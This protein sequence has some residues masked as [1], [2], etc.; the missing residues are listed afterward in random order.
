MRTDHSNYYPLI[1]N[2]RTHTAK[3]IPRRVLEPL[4]KNL[5]LENFGERIEGK[6]IL[7][8]VRVKRELQERICKECGKPL[9]YKVEQWIHPEYSD[10]FQYLPERVVFWAKIHCESCNNRGRVWDVLVRGL[11]EPPTPVLIERIGKNEISETWKVVYPQ[12]KENP[13]RLTPS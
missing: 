11:E 5:L 3:K 8:I 9:V 2:V 4:I 6:D 12:K 1:A 13:D 10:K 7:V